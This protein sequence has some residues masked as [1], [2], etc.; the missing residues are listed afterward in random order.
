MTVTRGTSYRVALPPPTV[1]S[2]TAIG[3]GSD[4]QNQER[5]HALDLSLGDLLLG[6]NAAGGK[7]WRPCPLSDYSRVLAYLPVGYGASLKDGDGARGGRMEF[8]VLARKDGHVDL[9][10]AW[11]RIHRE[12]EE[13]SAVGLPPAY[14]PSLF[15]ISRTARRPTGAASSGTLVMALRHGGG[16]ASDGGPESEQTQQRDVEVRS[17]D[18]LPGTL[19]KPRMRTLRMTLY[20]GGGAGGDRFVP[21]AI[22]SDDHS[23]ECVGDEA[24]ASGGRATHDRC[25]LICHTHVGLSDLRDHKLDLRSDG[26]ILL[27]RTVRLPPDSSLWMMVDFDEAYL[28][29]QK[30]PADANRGVDAF[31]SRATFT[32]VVSAPSPTTTATSPSTTLYSP[33]LL[34]LPPV[35]DM[36]MPFNV[37]SLSCTLWAF[38]L[39]SLLNIL[40]RRGTESVKR[41]FTGE[42]E[43]RPLD[44]LKEKIREK[45]NKLKEKLRRMRGKLLRGEKAARSQ[46]GGRSDQREEGSDKIE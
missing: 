30:F 12:D 42:K 3:Q 45:G 38:V 17:L 27:E 9:A 41:E 24:E 46:E 23:C 19:I 40:V 10:A 5:T 37:I 15:G 32:P 11:A 28:P 20:L 25:G 6:R 31:P 43:K 7:A 21:P 2:S 14:H 36:S 4:A 26:T 1:L 16:R 33:S 13:E 18:V 29:F 39:G 44:R 34:L 8:D 35:P 22:I